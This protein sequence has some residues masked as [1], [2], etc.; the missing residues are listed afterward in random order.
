MDK[1]VNRTIKPYVVSTWTTFRSTFP[2]TR[3]IEDTVKETGEKHEEF[4]NLIE[5]LCQNAKR[6]HF[7]SFIERHVTK[8]E[9]GEI[10]KKSLG[11]FFRAVGSK[12]LP[13]KLLGSKKNVEM[14]LKNINLLFLAGKSTE[15]CGAELIRNID[16]K[17]I[18]W[19]LDDTK[20][21]AEIALWMAESIFWRLLRKFFHITG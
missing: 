10:N 17:L 8:N 13:I 1:N 12:I 11:N 19:A 5:K 3:Q 16:V 15:I 20:F 6:T 7:K 9:T 4:P 14:F 18:D 21:L 2:E